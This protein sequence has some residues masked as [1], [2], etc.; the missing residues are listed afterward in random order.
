MP[1]QYTA[2]LY[3]RGAHAV[4]YVA[5]GTR[6]ATFDALPS[7]QALARDAVGDVPSLV[8]LNKAD[9]ADAW[10]L[11]RVDEASLPGA[12]LHHV[13]TSARTGAGVEDVFHRLAEEV[14]RADANRR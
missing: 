2:R 4:L 10:A 14:L 13:R 7:L 12:G 6:R 5:D 8:A 11:T 9:L 3:T 1:G